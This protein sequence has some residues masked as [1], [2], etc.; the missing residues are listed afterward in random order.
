MHLTEG[1]Q[2][3]LD[4]TTRRLA[5]VQM[6]VLK[7]L[8]SVGVAEFKLVSKWGCDGSSGH[9]RYKQKFQDAEANDEYSFVFSLVPIKLHPLNDSQLVHGKMKELLPHDF[10][11]Q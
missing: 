2:A 10:V 9:G 5:E 8:V 11:V 6:P 4:H 1:L 3:L 7:Y